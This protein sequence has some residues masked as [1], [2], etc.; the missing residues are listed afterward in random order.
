MS[1][2]KGIEEKKEQMYRY[3]ME[4]YNQGQQKFILHQDITD[5]LLFKDHVC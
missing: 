5:R 2:W 1:N 4:L 3:L